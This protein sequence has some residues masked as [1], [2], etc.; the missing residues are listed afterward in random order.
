M[1]KKK[2]YCLRG[3]PRTPENLSGRGCKKCTEERSAKWY[4]ENP[5][6]RSAIVRRWRKRN[7]HY[8]RDWKRRNQEKV[9]GYQLKQY[10]GISMEDYTKIR[11]KQ[12]GE[13]AILG[14]HT[15]E[16][17]TGRRLAVDHSHKTGKVRGLLCDRCNTTLGK[18]EENPD[19]LHALLNYFDEPSDESCT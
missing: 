18:M 14:C 3:H 7:P 12:N 15:T 9:R 2:D 6:R 8:I 11:A 4:R 17:K 1:G 16:E 10:Y 13:C 5:K 19:L